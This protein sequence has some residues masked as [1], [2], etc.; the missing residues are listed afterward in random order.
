MVLLDAALRASLDVRV[1][2]L[3]CMPSSPLLCA[4][5]LALL[6]LRDHGLINCTK[7]LDFSLW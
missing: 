6:A 7:L 3:L 2:A 5:P 4:F 1:S